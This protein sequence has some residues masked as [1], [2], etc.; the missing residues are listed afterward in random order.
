M[1]WLRLIRFLKF[2]KLIVPVHSGNIV[3]RAVH[4]KGTI[5]VSHR[6]FRKGPSFWITHIYVFMAVFMPEAESL[7]KVHGVTAVGGMV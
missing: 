7:L 1:V 3:V 2:V 6:R 4:R 5:G